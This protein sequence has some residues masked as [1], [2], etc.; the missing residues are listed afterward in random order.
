MLWKILLWLYLQFL[1]SFWDPTAHMV[2][3]A[4][5]AYDHINGLIQN[6]CSSIA[7]ALE[8]HLFCIKLSVWL[9]QLQ[10][11]NCDE[12]G[13]IW[14]IPFSYKTKQAWTVCLT[15]TSKIGQDVISLY[16]PVSVKLFDSYGSH[17]RLLTACYISRL[18]I[19]C[20]VTVTK[21]GSRG[22]CNGVAVW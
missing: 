13:Q 8:L 19:F 14:M 22:R 21:N 17:K 15:F 4:W 11:G 12:Y 18:P 3:V 20:P 2:Q 9:S 7:N 5:M 16:V 1:V 6:R 10:W